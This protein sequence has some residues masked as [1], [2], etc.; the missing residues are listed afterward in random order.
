MSKRIGEFAEHHDST[1][2]EQE[3][4]KFLIATA[5][6][7]SNLDCTQTQD[8]FRIKTY[9]AD[10]VEHIQ[11]FLRVLVKID[12]AESISFLR[13]L[14]TA[15]TNLVVH[16]SWLHHSRNCSMMHSELNM[17]PDSLSANLPVIWNRHALLF[18]SFTSFV[19]QFFNKAEIP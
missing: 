4:P 11:H 12:V 1:N 9:P 18:A 10:E 16:E 5:H 19:P 3:N 8:P 7:L 14:T 2:A 6:E 13:P 17:N 15:S